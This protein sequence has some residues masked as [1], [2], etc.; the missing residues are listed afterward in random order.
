MRYFTAEDELNPSNLMS[1]KFR[2]TSVLQKY[3]EA[4]QGVT[5]RNMGKTLLTLEK[6]KKHTLDLCNRMAEQKLDRIRFTKTASRLKKGS[7]AE[8]D[9]KT[10][11]GMTT[12]SFLTKTTESRFQGVSHTAL[13]RNA[14]FFSSKSWVSPFFI[15]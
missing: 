5:S 2:S 10:S 7:K 12:T 15:F 6:Q 13:Q 3:R 9:S 8:A 11:L 1:K 4:T 14:G